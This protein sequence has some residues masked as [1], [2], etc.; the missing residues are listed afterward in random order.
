[1]KIASIL[2]IVGILLG[3]AAPTS[4]AQSMRCGNDFVKINDSAFVVVKKCGEPVSKV[5]MGYTIDIKNRREL[6]IEEWIY[7]PE[8]GGYYYFIIMIGGHVSEIRS[9]RP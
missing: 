2:S 4:L 7:G 3:V 1:M 5:H 8:G 6:I 9:E